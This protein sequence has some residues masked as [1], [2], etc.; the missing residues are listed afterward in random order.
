GGGKNRGP[1]SAS[2]GRGCQVCGLNLALAQLRTSLLPY[3]P[4]AERAS[5]VDWSRD[6]A[7]RAHVRA[8]RAQA[9]AL[10]AERARVGVEGRGSHPYRE[11][12]RATARRGRLLVDPIELTRALVARESPTFAEGPATD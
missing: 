6:Q 9:H 4:D 7:C 3:P 1:V 2:S 11:P 12:R 5:D 10:S 8:D